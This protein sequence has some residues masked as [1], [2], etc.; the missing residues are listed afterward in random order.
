MG[1]LVWWLGAG[2]RHHPRPGFRG[3]RHLAGLAGLVA[4]QTFNSH[5]GKA[6]LPPPHGRPADADALC[7]PLRRVPIRRGKYNA[8][9]LD[10]LV[11]PVAIGRD[12]RQLLALRCAQNHTYLLCHGPL[13]LKPWSIIAHPS[14]Q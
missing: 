5:L 4:Q 1:R 12:R 8:R 9:P 11:R 2:Q 10:V 6:L 14:A 7:H 13:S 3:D